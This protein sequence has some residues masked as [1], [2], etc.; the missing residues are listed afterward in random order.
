MKKFVLK[1]A[2]YSFIGVIVLFSVIVLAVSLFAPQKISQ[3]CQDVG[4]DN[5]AL[6]YAK[7]AY[8]K[9]KSLSNCDYMLKIAIKCDDK[10][11]LN[12]Y[13]EEFLLDEGLVDYFTEKNLSA[14]YYDFIATHYV[15]ST[16]KEGESQSSEYIY[17]AM[18]FSLDYRK[19][20]AINAVIA[21]SF[22]NGDVGALEIIKSVLVNFYDNACPEQKK[23][24]CKKTIDTINLYLDKQTQ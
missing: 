12:D 16:Y 10:V 21:K 6:Y 23:T 1:V 24:D 7:K 3:I 17:K 9:D 20:C 4:F 14:D 2:G 19:G 8:L 5:T 13:G 22:E 11:V 15:L 18:S